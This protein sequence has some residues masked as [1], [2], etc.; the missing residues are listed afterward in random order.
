MFQLK[1]EHLLIRDMRPEDEDAFVAISQDEKY[2]RFYDE[3][4][5]DPN[6]YRK[7]TQLFIAQANE[8]PRRSYQLAIEHQATG[9]FIGTVCLRLEDNRQASMGCGLS[10]HHQGQNLMI[11]AARALADFGFQELNIHRIYAETIGENKAAIHLCRRLGMRQEAH[12]HQHRFFK[13]Q[14]WDTVVLAILK[15]EWEQLPR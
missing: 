9:A 6:K 14:W 13:G 12:F 3:S 15:S 10:R 8:V 11:E 4:D 7:L 1:T 5:C 2:Q